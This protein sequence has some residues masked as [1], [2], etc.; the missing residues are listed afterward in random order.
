M[1]IVDFRLR[2]PAGAFLTSKIYA[3]PD[4]R[5]RYT[6][7]LGFEPAPSAVEQSMPK[8]IEEMDDAG[9]TT[10]VAVARN[11]DTLGVI[12]NDDV[13][14]AVKGYEDRLVPVGSVHPANRKSA[15][16]EVRRAQELGLKFVNLEPGV[17]TAPMYV[18]DRRLYPIYALCE[19]IG[20]GVVLM[21]GGGAGPDITYSAPEH[22]DRV[23]AD[24]P[25]LTVVSSHGN[26]P[27]VQE[28]IHIAFRRSNLYLCPD[29]Y[30][31]GLPGTADYV[32]AANGFMAEQ[33][34]FGTAYP[35]CPFKPYLDKFLAFDWK[36]DALEK[37]L[38]KNATRLLGLP[39]PS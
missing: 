16:E 33:F 27:W 2:P 29:M 34:L 12:T 19:D 38:W 4:N 6:H 25:N 24:F 30:L 26:W 39:T 17:L 8:L 31:H 32:E 20:M 10:G 1:P 35:F 5:D 13:V 9:I 23:L 22:I 28:I 14:D 15:F 7:K 18:D 37:V 36:P 3:N 21:S 11:T